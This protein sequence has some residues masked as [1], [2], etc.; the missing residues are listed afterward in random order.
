MGSAAVAGAVSDLLC[1]PMFVVRTR[2]QT[3]ALHAMMGEGGGTGRGGM[4]RPKSVT[5]TIKSLYLEGGLLIFWR[6]MMANI[7]GLSHVAIQFPVYESLKYRMRIHNNDAEKNGPTELLVASALS[8]MMACLVSY[9]HE[10]IRSRMQDARMRHVGFLESCQRIYMKEGLF[11]FYSGLP[12]TLLRVLPNTCITFISYEL[13][14]QWARS[15]I[16]ADR[17]SNSSSSSSSST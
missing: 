15:Q 3:D 7:V 8:K 9:P 6:G 16:E 17:R 2:L 1:N 11:G 5:E 4:I 14:L 13:L 10:V 12:I